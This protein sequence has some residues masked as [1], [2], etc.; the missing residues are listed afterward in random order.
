MSQKILI[1]GKSESS[2]TSERALFGRQGG[3]KIYW[4]VPCSAAYWHFAPLPL[5]IPE[6]TFYTYPFRWLPKLSPI[7]EMLYLQNL[8]ILTITGQQSI[9][10]NRMLNQTIQIH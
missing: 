4:Y 10:A 7:F 5:P 8:I 2:L 6:V 1:I 3:H 9:S